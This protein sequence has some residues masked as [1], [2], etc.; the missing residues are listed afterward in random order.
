M[1]LYVAIS[2]QHQLVTDRHT[3]MACTVLAWCHA[4]YQ[5]TGSGC[6]ESPTSKVPGLSTSN[7]VAPRMAYMRT[8]H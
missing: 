6:V 8:L 7:L 3:T 1:I 2:V 5:S 4:V